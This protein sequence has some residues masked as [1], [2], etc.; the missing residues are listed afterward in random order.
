MSDRIQMT[1]L[2]PRHYIGIRRRVP[3]ANI[4]QAL[5]EAFPRVRSWLNAR[6]ITPDSPPAVLFDVVDW[7]SDQWEI[8]PAI[9]LPTPADPTNDDPELITGQTASGQALVT[10]H[11][12]PYDGLPQT[13]QAVLDRAKELNRPV[14]GVPWEVYLDD[15]R[16]VDEEQL[17]TEIVV[18]LG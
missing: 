1:E 15:P 4:S 13:W 2:S 14:N 6:G 7:D 12:G 10:T 18:P 5:D 16:V 17:R 9:F 3:R 11:V 8:T